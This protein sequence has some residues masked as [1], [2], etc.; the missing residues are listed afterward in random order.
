MSV[1]YEMAIKCIS[2]IALNVDQKITITGAA[3]A[4]WS[5]VP[6]NRA[7]TADD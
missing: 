4:R 3:T 5:H 2:G 7:K 1:L 6:E